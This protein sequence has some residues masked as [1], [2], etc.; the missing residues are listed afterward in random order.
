MRVSAG[1]KL[2]I[3]LIAGIAISIGVLVLSEVGHLRLT[4]ANASIRETQETLALASEIEGLLIGA[5]AAQ[6]G[7]LLTGET[8]YAEPYITASAKLAPKLMRL[9]ALCSDDMQELAHV[10]RL[11][12]LIATRLEQLD[13][14]FALYKARGG[15]AARE[16][17]RTHI[18][19]LTTGRIRVEIDA[20]QDKEQADLIERIYVWDRDVATSR[21]AMAAITAF[22]IVLLTLLY[23]VA[24]H[25]GREREATRQR[26]LEYQQSLEREVRNRTAELSA[27]STSL[28]R[29]QEAERARL[30][31]ELH[32]EMGSLLVSAKMD[33]SWAS[34]RIKAAHPE[35]AEK[36]ARALAAMD[37]GVEVKRRLVDDLRPAILDHL[38]LAAAITWYAEQM[39][40]RSGLTC[41]VAIADEAQNAVPPAMAIA[42]FR[43]VQE[44]LTNIV[45]HAKATSVWIELAR[46]EHA[47]T[48]AVRDD[49]IG[50]AADRQLNPS[51]HGIASMRQRV[52]AMEGRFEIE[53]QPGAG[54]TAKVWVPIANEANALSDGDAAPHASESGS[55]MSKF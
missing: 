13:A 21:F 47:L 2:L 24:R 12:A 8:E 39:A 38:G 1:K 52:I 28:Q 27:L 49:G 42:L 25:D 54:T 20:I 4:Q 18:G 7:L 23:A 15:P 34:N 19:R 26:L 30:A 50:L 53:S 6:R 22:N 5:E 45:R 10:E 40:E 29:V 46:S 32:D 44:A 55:G 33:V 16:L 41:N 36:L 9:H 31:R 51:A 43:V 17:S 11:A 3:P 35:A 48:L 14:A 37:E